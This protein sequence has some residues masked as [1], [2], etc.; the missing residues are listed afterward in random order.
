MVRAAVKLKLKKIR[1]TPFAR[2]FAVEKLK[3]PNL[4]SRLALERRN[5][6]DALEEITNLE[7]E[8]TAIRDTIK[9]CAEE[10]VGRRRGKKK[11][12]WIKDST[13]QK[14]DERKYA[15][16]KREQAK[17][18]SEL[19]EAKRRYTELDRLVKKSSR[20]DKNDW[21][22]RKGAEAQYAVDHGD[23]KTLYRIVRELTANRNNSNVPI[24]DKNGRLLSNSDEQNQRWLE[25]F[26]DILDQPSPSTTYCFDNTDPVEQLE[27]NT[28]YITK[29]EVS[30][31]IE[32]PKNRK[33]SGL[34]EISAELLKAG[35]TVVVEK[36]VKL[37]NRCW[38]QGEV[39]EDGRRGVIVKIPKKGNLSDCS[40]WRGITLLSV[41]GKTFC[42]VLLRRICTAIDGQLREEQAG[43]RSGRSCS[44]QI[45]TLRNIVEQCVP[46][47]CHQLR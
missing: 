1:S 36:L 2:P 20:D 9:V 5:R 28:G 35:S 46:A 30:A 15:K 29:E 19:E 40:N 8:W 7:D 47:A 32:C 4:A 44:E 21:L 42:I 13:W 11:E 22:I 38:S 10:V 43:F 31:A 26:R 23:S 41:P 16:L 45:F 12:E 34:E 18:S 24:R 6:F 33:S 27:V 17:T 3:D 39:P 25:Y 14:I 37:F